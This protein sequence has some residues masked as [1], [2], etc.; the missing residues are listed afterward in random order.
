MKPDEQRMRDVLVDT[1]RLLCRTGID[2]SRRLRVQGLLG[3][4]VDDEHVFLIHVDDFIARNCTDVDNSSCGF[5]DECTSASRGHINS[6]IVGA[7]LRSVDHKVS[8]DIRGNCTKQ[9]QPGPAVHYPKHLLLSQ[10]THNDILTS[11]AISEISSVVA[12]SAETGDLPSSQQLSQNTQNVLSHGNTAPPVAAESCN[13]SVHFTSNGNVTATESP[14]AGPSASVNVPQSSMPNEIA[15]SDKNE[16]PVL[17]KMEIDG[18]EDS[19]TENV[20]VPPSDDLQSDVTMCTATT[21]SENQHRV[22]NLDDVDSSSADTNEDGDSDH[23]SESDEMPDHLT[24][25]RLD[26]ISSLQYKPQALVGNASRWP[27]AGVQRSG[28]DAGADP[29]TIQPAV[30]TGV[31]QTGGS[32][33]SAYYQQQVVVFFCI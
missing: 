15:P 24:L 12:T 1:I 9:H 29:M 32:H 33:A 7:N 13:E 18:R 22:L 2:Y 19:K 14:T 27:I 17:V 26:L 28:S 6:D 10:S 30:L 16:I 3:I 31:V 21:F 8:Q 4:T 11:V 25:P 5:A 23:T 20:V